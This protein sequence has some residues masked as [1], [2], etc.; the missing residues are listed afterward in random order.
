MA[1]LASSRRK[2]GENNP[3]RCIA[4]TPILNKKKKVEENIG[5]DADSGIISLSSQVGKIDTRYH[6]VELLKALNVLSSGAFYSLVLDAFQLALISQ[7]KMAQTWKGI[8]PVS[9][10]ELLRGWSPGRS[11]L[12]TGNMEFDLRLIVRTRTLI[13]LGLQLLST[14]RK[15]THVLTLRSCLH[16]T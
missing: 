3:R 5:G 4:A 10:H 2:G 14:C 16:L 13:R 12:E 11:Q 9:T 7:E 8:K 15:C 6:D 1:L